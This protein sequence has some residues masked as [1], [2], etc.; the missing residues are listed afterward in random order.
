VDATLLVVLPRTTTELAALDLDAKVEATGRRNGVETAWVLVVPSVML[1]AL[2][3]AF[4][5]VP[6]NFCPV[7]AAPPTTAALVATEAPLSRRV[8][9]EPAV[10]GR[11]DA[12]LGPVPDVAVLLATADTRE[13]DLVASDGRFERATV[14][15]AVEGV[16]LVATPARADLGPG[17]TL[18]GMDFDWPAMRRKGLS[19]SVGPYKKS[20]SATPGAE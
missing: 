8:G 16:T 18:G 2:F 10:P 4:A 1:P 11:E 20:G 14:V 9:T 13:T 15:L 7:A 3:L 6:I 17:L 12:V 5:V 19:S